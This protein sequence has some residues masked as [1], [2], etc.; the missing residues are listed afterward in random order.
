SIGDTYISMGG[1]LESINYQLASEI[2]FNR[3]L[4]FFYRANAKGTARALTTQWYSK[5]DLISK[6]VGE[7]N[8]RYNEKTGSSV[9]E[10]IVVSSPQKRRGRPKK[11]RR[12]ELPPANKGFVARELR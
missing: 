12:R 7:M 11:E 1:S 2:F 8:E 5:G 4:Y 3:M 10:A 9:L 6:I